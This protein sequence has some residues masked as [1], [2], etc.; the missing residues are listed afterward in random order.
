MKNLGEYEKKDIKKIGKEGYEDN[1]E[2][3]RIEKI[4]VMK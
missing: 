2:R 4:M 3:K 1:E